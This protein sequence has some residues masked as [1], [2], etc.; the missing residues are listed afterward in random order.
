MTLAPIRGA[1]A[2]ATIPDFPV[3]EPRVTPAQPTAVPASGDQP[4][5]S[6][7]RRRH[8]PIEIAGSGM[9][10]TFT[11]TPEL[12]AIARGSLTIHVVADGA[13]PSTS[14][15]LGFLR[16]SAANARAF[17]TNLRDARSPIVATGD[18][19]GTVQIEYEITEAGPVFFVRNSGEQ[20]ALHCCVIDRGFDLKTMADELLAN[21]GA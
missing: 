10:L 15:T 4:P 6:P 20:H 18:E 3:E 11:V 14:R 5:I 9:S 7:L 13:G 12:P 17:L 1:P 8:T 2:G 19:D 21:L 16:M